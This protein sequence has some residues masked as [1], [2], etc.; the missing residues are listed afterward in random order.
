MIWP[1]FIAY[2]RANSNIYGYAYFGDGIRN[3][4]FEFLI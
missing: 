3:S 2:H 4:D 1:G